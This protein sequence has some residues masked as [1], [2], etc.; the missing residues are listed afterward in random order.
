MNSRQRVQCAFSHAQPDRPPCDYIATPE[1]HRALLQHF[2]VASEEDI[3][4]RLDADIQ[5]VNPPY[6]GPPL[7][8]FEDGSETNIWGVRR[9][10]MPNE[11]GDYAE[12]VDF[13]YREW[14]TLEQARGFPWPSPDWYDYEAVRSLCDRYPERALATGSYSVQDFINGVAFGRGVEQVLLDIA[15]EDP[16]YLYIVERR[17]KFYM[18]VV[19]R[20]LQAARGRIDFVLC[21]DDFGSQR[22]LLISPRSFDRLF[23]AKKKELFD[24]VHSYG[25]FVSHHCCGS[26]VELFPRF[27]ELGM[28]ALQTIQ[29]QA[30]GMNPYELKR[31]YGAQITLHGAVDVQGWLQRSGAAQIRQEVFRLIEQVGAGGGFILGPCHNIQPDTPLP[32]VLELYQAVA[33][34][35]GA[36]ILP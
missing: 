33:E 28:D 7:P 31:T 32:N 8:R 22:G 23:A 2:A 16:V 13:P 20:T 34:Y 10:P 9:R 30:A 11:Y 15:L 27:I 29:P 25:A 1:I 12:P 6:V 19:E 35:N 21:G 36:R 5:Y 14:T 3:R 17:H 18:E 26:S 4:E 24:M